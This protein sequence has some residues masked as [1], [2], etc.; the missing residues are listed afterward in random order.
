MSAWSEVWKDL[1]RVLR[2]A[3][4]LSS[5]VEP[6]DELMKFP[7]ESVDA[8]AQSLVGDVYLSVSKCQSDPETIEHHQNRLVTSLISVLDVQPHDHKLTVRIRLS[9]QLCLI[10][11][12]SS[13][14]KRI[15]ASKELAS[16]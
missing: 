1:Q 6:K 14:I 16:L 11:Y 4:D 7:G 10:H 15:H 13:S 12:D 9:K 8:L 5:A 2:A 3:P